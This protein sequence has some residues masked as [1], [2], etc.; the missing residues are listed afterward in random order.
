MV[1]ATI[2]FAFLMFLCA[3]TPLGFAAMPEFR[4]SERSPPNTLLCRQAASIFFR[5]KDGFDPRAVRISG[6]LRRFGNAFIQLT[7]ALFYA[8][9]L[10]ARNVF[11]HEKLFFFNRSVDTTN[12]ITIRP[13][14]VLNF[15]GHLVEHDFWDVSIPACLIDS[16]AVSKTYR[17]RLLD[18]LPHIVLNNSILAV[19]V[20]GGDI[21][22]NIF[23][24]WAYANLPASFILMLCGWII[25]RQFDFSVRIGLIRAWMAFSAETRCSGNPKA[26]KLRSP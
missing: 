7:A 3:L 8:D 11:I 16:M 19:H 9:V 1:D 4:F 18:F 12:Q 23:P 20:R 13:Q 2:Y 24:P 17:H 14:R 25:T 15:A 6:R 10:D 26:W 22:T 21:F 5:I